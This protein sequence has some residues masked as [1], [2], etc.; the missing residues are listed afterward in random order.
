[1]I[2]IVFIQEEKV[3]EY[4]IESKPKFLKP[5][6]SMLGMDKQQLEKQVNGVADKLMIHCY[7]ERSARLRYL[8]GILSKKFS[9]NVWVYYI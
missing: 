4:L 5:A 9:E 3:L 7:P 8:Y 1:M 2:K 6:D